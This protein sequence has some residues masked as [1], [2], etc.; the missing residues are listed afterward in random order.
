M[1]GGR[2]RLHFSQPRRGPIILA[3]RRA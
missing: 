1:R 2:V 3:I